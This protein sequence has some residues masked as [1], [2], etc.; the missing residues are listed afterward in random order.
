MK[1]WSAFAYR[2]TQRPGA[3]SA[4]RLQG[5][6]ADRRRRPGSG[7][8]RRAGARHCSSSRRTRDLIQRDRRGRRRTRRASR[9]SRYPPRSCPEPQRGASRAAAAV[10]PPTGSGSP[11]RASR[12]CR[13]S[14]Q[15]AI[16]GRVRRSADRL[17]R[18]ARSD[19]P[20]PHPVLVRDAQRAGELPPQIDDPRV[21]VDRPAAQPDVPLVGDHRVRAPADPQR[22]AVRKA[23]ERVGGLKRRAAELGEAVR[24]REQVRSRGSD[25]AARRIP[26]PPYSVA[27]TSVPL[28]AG[29]P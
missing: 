17:A 4:E 15:S 8:P 20:G 6:R 12:H 7:H 5:A 3:G 22:R 29:R 24:A 21:P 10:R 11:R 28:P 16:R 25:R 18:G 2:V 1:T 27:P 26:G 23:A 19:E 9:R 14:R 13:G